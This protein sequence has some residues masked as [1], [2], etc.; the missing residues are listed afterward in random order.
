LCAAPQRYYLRM[1]REIE[2]KKERL[3]VTLLG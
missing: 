3:F 1:V 2:R